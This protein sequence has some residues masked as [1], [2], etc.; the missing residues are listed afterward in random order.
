MEEYRANYVL[1]VKLTHQGL[2]GI[3]DVKKRY[4][5]FKKL[6]ESKGGKLLTEY[7]TLGRYDY[8]L[9]VDLPN[10]QAALEISVATGNKGNVSIE[11]CR[12]FSFAEFVKAAEKA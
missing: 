3:K 1:L 12:G 8:V 9:I 6:V 11:T 2:T 4:D 5:A 10:D 7:V